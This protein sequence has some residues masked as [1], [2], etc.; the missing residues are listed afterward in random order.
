MPLS[1][2]VCCSHCGSI[3]IGAVEVVEVS[4]RGPAGPEFGRFLLCRDCANE[5]LHFLRRRHRARRVHKTTGWWNAHRRRPSGGENPGPATVRR[6]CNAGW[7]RWT[8]SNAR[9]IRAWGAAVGWRPIR[10]WPTPGGSIRRS[11]RT[12]IGVWRRSGHTWPGTRCDGVWT[13]RGRSRCTI[14]IITLASSI[15][16]RRCM[17]C[18]TRGFASGSSSFSPQTPLY[19]FSVPGMPLSRSA[20]PGGRDPTRPVAIAPARLRSRWSLRHGDVSEGLA[21][22]RLPGPA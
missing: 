16:E 8:G 15:K 13:G 12:R 6:S 3:I 20:P 18:S 2:V 10:G 1:K 17:S 11:G 5:V 22:P 9:S 19:L 4:R 21:G 14:A 7:R